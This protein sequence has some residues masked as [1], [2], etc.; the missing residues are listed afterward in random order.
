MRVARYNGQGLDWTSLGNINDHPQLTM[1][2]PDRRKTRRRSASASPAT[3]V[4]TWQ[5]PDASGAARILAR[6]IFGNRLGTAVLDVSATEAQTGQPIDAEADAPAI[7]VSTFGEAKIAY[8]LA[9]GAG[10]AL[11]QPAHP[12]EHAAR[13]NGPQRRQAAGREG[14][15]RRRHARPAQPRDRQPSGELRAAYASG[16]AAQLVSGSDYDTVQ[17]AALF[18]ALGSPQEPRAPPPA[19]GC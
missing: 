7:A 11:W 1:R 10:L 15:R 14:A 3:P 13:R 19:H 5:E 18:G 16:G 4:V 8:R 2:H 6:R 9:G 12:A 17:R